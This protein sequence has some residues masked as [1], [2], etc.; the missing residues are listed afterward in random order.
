MH[1]QNKETKLTYTVG[2][3]DFFKSHSYKKPCLHA[4]VRIKKQKRPSPNV[5]NIRR[6]CTIANETSLE[7][8]K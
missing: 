5:Y 2:F 6:Y 4:C 3:K 7:H 8:D 1:D